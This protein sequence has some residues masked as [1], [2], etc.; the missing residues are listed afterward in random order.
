M[1]VLFESSNRISHDV[2][3]E[4]ALLKGQAP[5]KGLYTPKNIPKFTLDEIYTHKEMTYAEIAYDVCEKFVGNDFPKSILKKIVEKAYDFD[6]PLENLFGKTYIMRLDRGPTASFKDFAAR[7]MAGLMEHFLSKNNEKLLIL[8]ATS[9]DTGSAVANA[10]NNVKKIQVVVLYPFD[11]VTK[12]QR[13]QMTTLE[14]NVVSIGLDAKFDDCQALVKKAFSDPELNHLCLSSANSINIGRLIPQS[15]YYFW[16]YSRVAKDGEE[17]IFSIPS[18]NFGDLMGGL[19]AKKMGLPVK[20]FIAATNSNNEFPKFLET[21]EYTPISPS[22]ACISNAM[23]VGHPSNL[24]RIVHMY[25]GW[26]DETGN[27]NKKPDM[28]A[29]KKDIWSKS[30][31]DEETIAT[32]KSV[33]EKYSCILEPHGAVGVNALLEYTDSKDDILAVSLETADPAKFPDEIKKGLGLNPILPKALSNVMNK[34]ENII[35]LNADYMD[36][37]K[38]LLDNY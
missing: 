18:G 5:D 3:F 30:V 11:E 8:T 27:I 14:G 32:I 7:C 16:A 9:G 37:K 29:L 35:R 17:I 6:V 1:E 38:Y 23:N 15:I 20:K 21:M 24:A 22:L 31:T 12:R 34:K 26:M 28:E 33:Y 2:G 13:K 25:G 36:L 19:I 4:K 10:F